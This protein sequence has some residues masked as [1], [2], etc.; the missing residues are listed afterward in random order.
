MPPDLELVP[1]GRRRFRD[2]CPRTRVEAPV[3][4]R[5]DHGERRDGVVDRFT[6]GRE[7]GYQEA[8]GNR[9]RAYA[10][11]AID[12]GPRYPRG[13]RPERACHD[14]RPRARRSATSRV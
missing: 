6:S 2:R 13:R 11:S 1:A 8:H 5:T 14:A 12:H 9:E 10:S 3:G 4:R 7:E